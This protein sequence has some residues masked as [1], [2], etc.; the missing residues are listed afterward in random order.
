MANQHE[1]EITGKLYDR[2]LIGRLLSYLYPYRLYVGVAIPLIIINSIIA[3]IG[4][5][6]TMVVV[7]LYLKPSTEKQLSFVSRISRDL[8]EISGYKPSLVE[9]LMFFTGLYLVILIMEVVLSYLQT[10]ILNSMGQYIMRD[11]R[12]QIFTKFQQIPLQF[13][14]QNPVGR[15]ITRLTTDIDSLNELMTSGF[16]ALVTDILT[17]TGILVFLFLVNWRLAIAMLLVL[18][19]MI[20]VT[21]WFRKNASIGFRKVR[22]KIAKL[23][24]FL[25]EHIMGMTIVQLFNREA[26]EFEQFKLINAEHRQVNV[27]TI[28]YYAVFYPAI[29]WVSALGTGLIIWYGGLQ[30]LSGALTLGALIF[31]IQSTQRFYEPIMDLSEKYNILQAAMASAE[32]VFS[33]LDTPITITSPEKAQKLSKIKGSIEFRNVWFAYKK[34]EWVLK[35]LSFRIEPGESIAIVGHT[36]AGKTTISSLLMR[37][38]DIQK[39]QILLDGVDIKELDLAELRQAF[40]IVLQDVFLFSGDIASNI[41]LGNKLIDESKMLTAA[42]EVHADK[43]ISLLKDGYKSE[44]NERGST[45]SVGQRQLLSFARALA[46]D[47]RILIL[48]EATSSVDTETEI[49]IRDAVKKLLTNRT[50]VI[51]AHRLSTIQSADKIIVMHKGQ[52][53]EMGSH[54][55]LLAKRGIYYKLYQLQYREEPVVG[56]PVA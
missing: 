27:E 11:M 43:F 3:L 41:T 49:L 23:N 36:G 28:F 54:Q 25:Q 42:K 46:F 38:Y 12:K 16:V 50:S 14:D 20:L 33:L 53:R 9:A 31:F 21:A 7:D 10:V 52:L 2:V 51:I 18:P 1:E 30:I 37:F 34:E 4:L 35:D 32:R 56:H 40:G 22:V 24:S 15:L 13:Y 8:I 39:G 26:R 6:V 45:L 19:L 17:L 5:N 29:S 47:P 44:L 55:E 48:D